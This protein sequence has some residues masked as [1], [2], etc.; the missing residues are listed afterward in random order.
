MKRRKFGAVAVIAC[1]ALLADAASASITLDE[2]FGSGG[3][4]TVETGATFSVLSDLA[5]DADDRVVVAGVSVNFPESGSAEPA[6][7]DVFVGRLQA[8]GDVDPGFGNNGIATLDLGES[9][10]ANRV[11]IQPDGKIVVL[12]I[13]SVLSSQTGASDVILV[14]FLED[15]ALDT[16]FG[17]D[18]VVTIDNSTFDNSADVALQSDGKILV[19]LASAD[20]SADP[21]SVQVIVR[22]L[23]S[24]GAVD[25]TYGTGGDAIL[26]RDEPS[27]LGDFAV[28][29]TNNLIAAIT[30][31]D[32][33][34]AMRI[35]PVGV[36]DPGFGEDGVALSQVG[37]SDSLALTVGLDP[38]GGVFVGTINP[39]GISGL[40]RFSGSGDLD[41]SFGRGG[42]RTLSVAGSM[43]SLVRTITVDDEGTITVVHGGLGTTSRFVLTRLTP[44]GRRDTT[45]GVVDLATTFGT[46]IFSAGPHVIDNS[47]RIVIGA[48]MIEPVLGSPAVARALQPGAPAPFA[49]PAQQFRV[50]G[51]DRIDTSLIAARAVH[52]TPPTPRGA[53]VLASAEAFPDALVG[54]PLAARMD[55]SLLLVA[56]GPLEARVRAEIDRVLEPGS[57]TVVILG[58]DR[59]V[60]SEVETELRDAGYAVERIAGADRFETA[61][62]VAESTSPLAPVVLA[63]GRE[64]PDALAAGAGAAAI[65]G[66][67]LLTDDNQ[68]PPA[69]Q[70]ALDARSGARRFAV[71]G[72]AAGADPSATAVVGGDRYDTAA[73]V[74]DLF[75]VTPQSAGIASGERFADAVTGGALIARLGG[76]LLLVRPTD[77]PSSTRDFLVSRAGF[78]EHVVAFGGPAVLSDAVLT[79]AVAATG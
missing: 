8:N 67:V 1:S 18:G 58:G 51:S 16:T 46:P 43:L 50:G 39:S 2:S 30:T 11:A 13:R 12:G 24:A 9:E 4:T 38:N 23:T 78:V 79:D 63:T 64:F 72:P 66:V 22:R 48:Q 76:P 42:V 17:Q 45:V 57:G 26:F 55:A 73:Q 71:G 20:T 29:G 47:G 15:G 65:G 19:G 32:G 14:R 25:P 54:A 10:V 77:L 61:A 60:S 37:V 5:T 31:E 7:T 74:A 3:V 70:T 35:N 40:V 6:T 49:G 28:D 69:T 75:F 33:S 62:K 34:G 53:V 41:S 21:P 68:I 56:A 44:D 52:P 36:P 27:A 59:A